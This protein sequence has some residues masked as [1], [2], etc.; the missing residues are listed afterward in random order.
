MK[1]NDTLQQLI[2]FGLGAH[3]LLL[4]DDSL[5]DILDIV[6]T[7]PGR[8]M[9]C[10]ALRNGQ[11]VYVKIFV[12]KHASLYAARDA[13]GVMQLQHAGIA[14]PALLYDG[15]LLDAH[16]HVLIFSAILDAV[17]AEQRLIGLP[18][19]E[20]FKLAWDLVEQ[21]AVHHQHQ[22]LQTDMYLKNFLVATS[23]IFT[24]DGDG[25]RQLTG[26]WKTHKKLFNL[27][28]LLSKFD[29]LD[30]DWIP[31]L[32]QHYCH[33]VGRLVNEPE[34][35]QLVK[36]IKSIRTTTAS[37]YADKKVFR[38]CT[39]VSVSRSFTS[40]RASVAGFDMSQLTIPYLDQRL[41]DVERNLKNGKT[42]SVGLAS[43]RQ[44]TVVIKRYNIKS[45]WH[46]LNRAF[47]KSRAAI[48]WANAHRLLISNVSTAKPFAL[49]EER[50]GWLHR[51]AYY[52]TEYIDAPDLAEYFSASVNHNEQKAVAEGV[53]KV[54]HQLWRLRYSHG[55]M[56]AT[57][58]KVLNLK[59][60][61]IDL[62]AMRAYRYDRVSTYFFKCAHIRDLKRLLLNW[63]PDALP[64]DFIKQ[65]LLAEYT[66]EDTDILNAMFK[67]AGLA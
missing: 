64:R 11:A 60:I 55:D 38:N 37:N 35:S 2:A 47:R 59:P 62:D 45:F 16:G 25:I 67:R 3:R 20:R 42:C 46:G 21:V 32:Y 30:D 43:I 5:L 54:M 6:R 48:S 9:V 27:A 14:T 28:T 15:K 51:R 26:F 23:C 19:A 34:L 58:I 10:R 66:N 1:S 53:A 63:P 65:A 40:L 49:V 50:W 29:A 13:R 31:D 33:H 8:R 22:L 44:N 24:L 57:N 36:L 52:L 61:L 12:G 56:K 17:N 4:A 39:D 7:V 18:H 41:S